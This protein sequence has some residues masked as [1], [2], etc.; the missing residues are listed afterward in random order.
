MH[1]KYEI[2]SLK[3]QA[4]PPGPVSKKRLPELLPLQSLTISIY[5][6]K[7]PPSSHIELL[8]VLKAQAGQLGAL[9]RLPQLGTL[10][11]PAG[12][13]LGA[14]VQVYELSP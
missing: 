7:I 12:K 6:A 4:S 13:E 9:R 2:F 5:A 10:I 3:C 8:R 14:A 11:L 1:S